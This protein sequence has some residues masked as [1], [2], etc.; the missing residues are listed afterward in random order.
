MGHILLALAFLLLVGG[1]VVVAITGALEPGA[2]IF[3]GGVVMMGLHTFAR[4][5]D[6]A[7]AWV[8]IFVGILAA[9]AEVVRLLLAAP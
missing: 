6:R 3:C 2:L 1:P 5:Q 8:L 9:A 4:S 7:V